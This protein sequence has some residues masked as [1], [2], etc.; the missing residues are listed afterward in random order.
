[1]AQTVS[2]PALDTPKK[3]RVTHTHKH[4]FYY[5][6][7][8]YFVFVFPSFFLLVLVTPSPSSFV[9]AESHPMCFIDKQHNSCRCENG[10]LLILL[11]PIWWFCYRNG[12]FIYLF[13][14]SF[15]S[16]NNQENLSINPNGQFNTTTAFTQHWLTNDGS[17][18]FQFIISQTRE[19]H[20]AERKERIKKIQR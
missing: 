15:N 6:D 5:Y 13:F 20:E 18:S 3:T 8:D 4:I 11:L 1:M 10:P 9:I 19:R 14:L 12:R 7:D 17:S 2:R 16:H